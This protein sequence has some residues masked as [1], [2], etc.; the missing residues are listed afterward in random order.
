MMR[1]QQEPHARQQRHHLRNRIDRDPERDAV[2]GIGED[3][4]ACQVQPRN[5]R[6]ISPVHRALE[7]AAD[8]H[9]GKANGEEQKRAAHDQ[10]QQRLRHH[11]PQHRQCGADRG[12]ERRASPEPRRVEG[13]I[14]VHHVGPDQ[15]QRQKVDDEHRPKRRNAQHR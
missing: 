10:R 4:K 2:V 14:A 6:G 8:A 5:Q 9:R 7:E 12:H 3:N 15:A 1:R 13:G 11:D